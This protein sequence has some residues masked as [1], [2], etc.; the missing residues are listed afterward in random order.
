MF[1]SFYN[2]VKNQAEKVLTAKERFNMAIKR[3]EIIEPYL[4]DIDSYFLYDDVMKSF[5]KTEENSGEEKFR[6]IMKK[7]FV[8]DIFNLFYNPTNESKFSA[9]KDS[10]EFRYK[11]LEKVN[12]SGIKI[13]SNKS[14][15]A[16]TLY[17]QEIA[18]YFYNLYKDLPPE[19]LKQLEQMMDGESEDGDFEDGEEGKGKGKGKGKQGD[20]EGKESKGPSGGK[21]AGAGD[22]NDYVEELLSNMLDSQQSEKL[23]EKAIEEVKKKIELMENSGAEV[24]E[25]NAREMIGKIDLLEKHRSEITQLNISREAIL[26]AVKKIL[27]KST[28][29]FSA[30]YKVDEVDIY[31]AE[32]LNSLEGIEFL[33]PAFRKGS[34][35]QLI[36]REKR[37]FGKY[38]LYVDNSGSMSSSAG[39][40]DNPNVS[41]MLLAKAIALKMKRLDLLNTLYEFQSSVT[42]LENTEMAIFDMGARG[43]TD[44]TNVIR[45]V[46]KS[47]ENS[48]VLTD[49]EDHVSEY[50]PNVV[51]LGVN[52]V[53][54][55]TFKSCEV[56]RQYIENNQCIVMRG[57]SIEY[58]KL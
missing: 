40:P 32:D 9:R 20:K 18:K 51:F 43:G 34:I 22:S 8:N 54:F 19:Q 26:K 28:S 3:P 17:T 2:K 24:N 48:V 41:C 55:R 36:T 16:S 27:D 49:A 52:G 15:F 10:N 33:H 13:V 46:K 42:K 23:L 50:L 56:G 21:S 14:T 1:K 5:K 44:I 12:R 47:G 57:N 39:L 38:D 58:A 31:S 29:Y 53:D 45:S 4:N 7:H 35:D 30:R 37:Y 11:L 25:S 6:R